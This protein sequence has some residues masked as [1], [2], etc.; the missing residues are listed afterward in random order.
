MR[1]ALALFGNIRVRNGKSAYELA[2][3]NGYVGTLTEWLESLIGADGDDG[4]EVELRE[5]AGWVEWRYVGDAT[6]TQLFEIP[7]GGTGS[8]LFP[9]TITSETTNSE[10]E[11]THTHELGNVSIEKVISGNPV[12]LGAIYNWFV[13]TDARKITSSDVWNVTTLAQ[14]EGLRA[15][16]AANGW[17]YDGTTDAGTNETNKQGKAVAVFAGWDSDFISGSV[18]NT[19]SYEENRNIIGLSAK[20]VGLRYNSGNY[21]NKNKQIFIW[22]SDDLGGIYAAKADV[23]YDSS[24]LG[25][26]SVFFKQNG[27]SVRLVADATGVPDGTLTKYTGNNNIEYSAIAINGLYWLTENINETNYRNGDWIHGFDEGVYTPISNAAWA[28]LETEAMCYYDDDETL[29]GGETPLTALI[30]PPVTIHPD[31]AAF[32][33]IDENQV[34]TINEP[35]WAAL[36]DKPLIPIGITNHNS[37]SGLQGGSET[38]RY[39]L[40]A[41]EHTAVQN[42]GSISTYDF[43]VGTAAEYAAID[44]KDANTIYHVEEV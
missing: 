19:G 31:S 38:E 30:H 3:Q 25:T 9:A 11:T 32:A 17:N 24:R 35:T 8:S 39:H 26:S 28:A 14:W 40:T 13:V 10:T 20:P 42:L 23:N 41:D 34:L 43:W 44:P 36:P 5:N 15:Y 12:D 16:I 21:A 4:R 33:S 27:I 18:G 29:G 7:T 37:L 6:W 22:C 2:V 1:Y